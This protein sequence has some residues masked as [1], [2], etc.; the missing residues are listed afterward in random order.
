MSLVANKAFNS[1]FTQPSS[2][3]IKLAKSHSQGARLAGQLLDVL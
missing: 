2:F 1:P 3:T